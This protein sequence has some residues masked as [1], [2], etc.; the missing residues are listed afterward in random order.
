[1]YPGVRSKIGVEVADSKLT[2]DLSA[3]E[4]MK[5]LRRMVLELGTGAVNVTALKSRDQMIAHVAKYDK[6]LPNLSSRSGKPRPVDEWV[7]ADFRPPSPKP[8]PKPRPAPVRRTLI[9]RDCH[10][11]VS[12]AKIAEIA[13]GL[14][15]LALAD[16]PHSISVLFRVFL[17]QSVDHYLTAAGVLLDM[18]TSGG[19][20]DKNLRAKV[21]E[22]V[23]QMVKT[24][25]P[26]RHLAGVERGI[27][28]R[29]N[30]LFIEA[31]HD[32]VHSRFYSPVE[33]ELKV[34][35][36]NSQLFFEKIW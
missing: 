18:P 4:V 7:D 23:A 1:L 25:T 33:R 34:A 28:D 15:T 26:K 24:G 12:N 17:E 8:K 31:L 11:T 5:P 30:P 29:N 36:D 3:I 35:W 19:K 21:G 10:L 2:T 16:F 6:D 13:K 14:R 9:P 20:R 27:D 22:A 32:Y